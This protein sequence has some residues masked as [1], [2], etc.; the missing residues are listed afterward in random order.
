MWGY[1][2]IKALEY[3]SQVMFYTLDYSRVFLQLSRNFCIMA[4]ERAGLFP[5][6]L[7]YDNAF[8]I[9]GST[10]FDYERSAI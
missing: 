10:S 6:V 7:E 2:Y 1:I 9:S 8:D 3:Y 5:N 4:T